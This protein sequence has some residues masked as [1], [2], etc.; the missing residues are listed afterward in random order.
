MGVTD[1]FSSDICKLKKGRFLL[2]IPIL[3]DL[4]TLFVTNVIMKINY[5]PINRTFLFK[6]GIISSPP[7][8]RYILEDFPSIIFGYTSIKGYTGLISSISLFTILLLLLSLLVG[9]FID[10]AYLSTLEKINFEKINLKYFFLLGNRNWWKFLVLRTISFI[11]VVLMLYNSSFIIL[12]FVMVVF[13]YVKFSMV[14]D[15]VSLKENFRNGLSFF[16][17]NLELSVKMMFFCGFIFSLASTVIFLIATHIPT[18]G[19]VFSIIIAAFLG[20]KVN[21]TVIELYRTSNKVTQ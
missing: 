2:L 1:M 13:Y 15:E 21:K 9:S 11:P 17:N 19:L 12:S 7:S 8:I 18:Y 4:I 10:S 20:L 6:L 3:L 14:V 5:I 16:M